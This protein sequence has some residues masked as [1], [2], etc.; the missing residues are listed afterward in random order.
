MVNMKKVIKNTKFN[1]D[2]DIPL[3]KLIYFPPATVIIRCIFVKK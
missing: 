3:N 1:T 2:D